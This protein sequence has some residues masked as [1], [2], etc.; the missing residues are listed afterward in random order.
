MSSKRVVEILTE[1]QENRTAIDNMTIR[2]MR[3]AKKYGMT[4][5][6]VYETLLET[7]HPKRK[8]QLLMYGV[9]DRIAI[10]PD[11]GQKMIE[12]AKT[13]EER[14]M[15]LRR[16]NAAIKWVS[17]QPMQRILSE[18]PLVERPK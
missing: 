14:D 11:F 12:F 13:P 4:D 7:G 1:E 17:E 8:A 3:G 18:E 9:Q 2:M 16:Y 6:Q 10:T 15:K 5:Q